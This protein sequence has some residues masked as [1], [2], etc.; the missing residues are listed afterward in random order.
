MNPSRLRKLRI[1]LSE[2]REVSSS[3]VQLT[4]VVYSNF[5]FLEIGVAKEG[6]IQ[7]DN[8]CGLII[9]YVGCGHNERHTYNH[10]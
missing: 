7:S 9:R 5:F 1:A 8:R 4:K 10:N 6:S 2:C 3:S